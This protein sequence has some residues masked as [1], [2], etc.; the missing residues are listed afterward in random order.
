[1]RRMVASGMGALGVQRFH[2]SKVLNHADDSVTARYDRHDYLDE[3]RETLDLWAAHL[4][5]VISGEKPKGKKAKGEKAT[6]QRR[7]SR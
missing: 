5:A 3:K 2:I 1:M 7:G 6:K 4:Q